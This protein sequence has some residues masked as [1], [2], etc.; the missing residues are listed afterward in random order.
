M[1]PIFAQ[2]RS[3][4]AG[5]DVVLRPNRQRLRL[6]QIKYGAVPVHDLRGLQDAAEKTSVI[7]QQ[8]GLDHI[9]IAFGLDVVVVPDAAKTE[10]FVIAVD[11]ADHAV[12]EPADLLLPLKVL[13][14]LLHN[15][16]DIM[17]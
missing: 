17:A 9:Q 12:F 11:N 6:H 1:A 13:L 2:L 3:V 4:S 7:D 16:L 8:H 5:F 10:R 15:H 14:S